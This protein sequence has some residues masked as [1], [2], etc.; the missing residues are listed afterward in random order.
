MS[1]RG[2]FLARHGETDWNRQRRIQGW[3]DVP[4]NPQ[5]LRQAEAL[6]EA[7]RPLQPRRVFTSDLSRSRQT[8]EVVSQLLG[9]PL[10]VDHRLREV[11]RGELDGY[12]VDLARVQFPEFFQV[13][14]QRPY[15][16][17]PP[18]GESAR[19]AERRVREF[20]NDW[21]PCLDR[22]VIVGHRLLNMVFLHLLGEPVEDP[23]DFFSRLMKNGEVRTLALPQD[24][25]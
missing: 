10:T 20:L 12:L 25:P 8:G 19:D 3:T 14:E 17:R 9:L 24:P 18:G 23:G 16:A 4:L 6:A 21:W 1:D 22:A 15:E 13:W 11:H 5:G 2:L 7:L